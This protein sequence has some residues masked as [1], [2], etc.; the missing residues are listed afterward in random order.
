MILGVSALIGKRV[1]FIRG[2][3]AVLWPRSGH[4]LSPHSM[5]LDL[6]GVH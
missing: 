2:C 6:P 1:A 5:G 4:Q 3:E